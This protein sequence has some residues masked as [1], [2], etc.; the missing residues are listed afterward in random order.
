MFQR[1]LNFIKYHNAFTIILGLVFLISASVLAA[2]EDIRNA[3]IGEKTVIEQ[4]TDNSQLL[5]A[6]LDNFNINLKINNVLEDEKNYYIDYSFNTI[7]VQD[8]VWQQVIKLEKFTVN[9]VGL[10]NRDLGVYLAGELGEVANSEISRLK[11]SQKAEKERGATKIVKTTNYSGLIGI[12]L[13]LK[14]KILPG[15]E[16]VVT[17]LVIDIVQQVIVEPEPEPELEPEPDVCDADNL[18]LCTNQADC[19]AVAGYW[20]SDTC[21]LE[22]EAN[23]QPPVLVCDADNLDLCITQELCEGDGLYW[24]SDTC[25]LE[26]NI[27]LCSHR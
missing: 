17:P 20:Y 19:E 1:I 8:N 14:N 21:N 15:Y 25:N 10:G 2:D 6:D 23:D 5:S 3:V 4:G 26:A 7:S 13:D 11:N 16:P 12:T 18:N 27:C 9:K 24:Y 22:A